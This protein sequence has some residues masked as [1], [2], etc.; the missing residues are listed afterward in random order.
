MQAST[1]R[2]DS[3]K[4]DLA[5]VAILANGNDYLPG[6]LSTFLETHPG[7]QG[8]WDAYLSLRLR[9]E[10]S[11][12]QALWFRPVSMHSKSELA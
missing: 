6:M 2:L 8:L 9:P 3:L 10:W 12:R 5:A 1:A 7:G 11:D 4:A